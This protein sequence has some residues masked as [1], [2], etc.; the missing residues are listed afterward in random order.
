MRL[1]KR[2]CVAFHTQHSNPSMFSQPFPQQKTAQR[3][4]KIKRGNLLSSLCSN[5]RNSQANGCCYDS[6]SKP[7]VDGHWDTRT[8]QGHAGQS[9]NLSRLAKEP[10]ASTIASCC[11]VSGSS[12]V[13]NIPQMKLTWLLKSYQKGKSSN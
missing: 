7:W 6:I 8:L 1:I 11:S 3:E 10:L 13:K 12:V 5:S 2:R 4:R 9:A